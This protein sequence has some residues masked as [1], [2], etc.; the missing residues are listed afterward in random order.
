MALVI[1]GFCLLLSCLWFQRIT[2]YSVIRSELSA[3]S[4]ALQQALSG[5]EGQELRKMFVHWQLASIVL[6]LGFLFFTNFFWTLV[7]G[8]HD[9]RYLLSAILAHVLWATSWGL[10][11]LPV[12]IKWRHW[13]HMQ[14]T[15]GISVAVLF[16][17]VVIVFGG[18]FLFG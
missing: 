8:Y 3:D 16:I 9:Q 4:S 11:S 18:I 12:I 2:Y 13:S 7:A 6:A 17:I 15:I 14:L 5:D 1:F 10:I